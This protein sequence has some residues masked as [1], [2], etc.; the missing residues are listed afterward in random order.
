MDRVGD[1]LPGVL[2]HLFQVD[3]V[4]SGEG[5]PPDLMEERVVLRAERDQGV[6]PSA[7]AAATD[8]V[9]V[10]RPRPGA[11]GAGQRPDQGGFQS[12]LEG[13][14]PRPAL[15]VDRTDRRGLHRLGG[16]AERGAA[17]QGGPLHP[18]GSA[19][20]GGLL[21]TDLFVEPLALDAQRGREVVADLRVDAVLVEP[22]AHAHLRRAMAMLRAERREGP[23][24]HPLNGLTQ[25]EAEGERPLD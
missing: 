9:G 4:A 3:L 17:D 1:L 2:R 19:L 20:R 22:D 25:A 15:P 23:P 12:E 7:G 21:P 16:A 14:Q 24:Q 6:A 5:V 13:P 10:V 11:D 18:S 8:V